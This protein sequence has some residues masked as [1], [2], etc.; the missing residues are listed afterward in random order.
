MHSMTMKESASPVSGSDYSVSLAAR[1]DTILQSYDQWMMD[2]EDAEYMDTGQAMQMLDEL[3]E[4]AMEL[5]LALPP[6]EL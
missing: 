2:C 4:L 1:S 5:R 3:K 6:E